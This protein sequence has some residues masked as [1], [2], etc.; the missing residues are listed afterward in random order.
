VNQ[1]SIQ[2]TRALSRVNS[3][4]LM[5]RKTSDL[6]DVRYDGIGTRK[7]TK[8]VRYQVQLGGQYIPIMQVAGPR[9]TLQMS[10]VTENDYMKGL[11]AGVRLRDFT[12]DAT[13]VNTAVAPSNH[14]G[15]YAI[16]LESSSSLAQSGSAL[17]AQRVLIFNIIGLDDTEQSRF[18]LAAK[19][20]TLATIFLDSV[21]VRS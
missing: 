3:V 13:V 20:V 9:E 15:R 12:Q 14:I 11:T 8:D 7:V 1:Q 17:S 4:S 5:I 21:V 10:F 16:T 6:N 2:V 19:H 18:V